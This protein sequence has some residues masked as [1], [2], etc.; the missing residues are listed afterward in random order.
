VLGAYRTSWV[1]LVLLTA[2]SPSV[3]YAQSNFQGDFQKPL[4]WVGCCVGPNAIALA[5]VN[6]DGNLDAITVDVTVN[7]CLGAGHGG[8]QHLAFY[9]ASPATSCMNCAENTS[10][11]AVGDFDHKGVPDIAVG[12]TNNIRILLGNGDGTFR[13]SG[14]YPVIGH[15]TQIALA[16]LNGDG[17]LDLVS[18]N[19]DTATLS[20]L[21][22]NGD[23][24]FRPASNILALII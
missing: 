6:G 10:A 18:A 20:V 4:W 3:V 8:F 19:T 15:P 14:D 9:S 23:G 17:N 1:I 24:T 22:G 7:V 21:L 16:D 5:D 13:I 2:V 12:S 11:L